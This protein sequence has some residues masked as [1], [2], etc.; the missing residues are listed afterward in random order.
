MSKIAEMVR[1]KKFPYITVSLIVL[2]VVYY[3]DTK[4]YIDAKIAEL[5]ALILENISNS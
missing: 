2:N 4:M 3:A 1:Q 5:Q